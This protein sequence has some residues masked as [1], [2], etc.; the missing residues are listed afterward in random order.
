[1]VR[2]LPRPSQ[3]SG[4]TKDEENLRTS[5]SAR[6]RT[7]P[8]EGGE[9]RAPGLP[10]RR[11]WKKVLGRRKMH[12][13]ITVLRTTINI[14]PEFLTANTMRKRRHQLSL[15]LIKGDT[16]GGPIRTSQ[17][18]RAFRPPQDLKKRTRD[19]GILPASQCL[20]SKA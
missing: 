19:L 20:N 4:S 2:C 14:L 5:K 13:S 18:E 11:Y 9:Q 7:K 6:H 10:D 12:S 15:P 8:D 16:H 1:M 17:G 3:K